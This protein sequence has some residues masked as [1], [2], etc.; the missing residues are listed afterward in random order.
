MILAHG[1][2]IQLPNNCSWKVSYWSRIICAVSIETVAPLQTT[3]KCEQIKW[4]WMN[5]ITGLC[6]FKLYIVKKI[7]V[8]GNWWRNFR[9]K[10][11]R[12]SR[13]F[14]KNRLK[15]VKTAHRTWQVEAL[16]R[17]NSDKQLLSKF[18]PIRRCLRLPRSLTS[19]MVVFVPRV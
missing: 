8:L 2:V 15:K 16:T 19:R 11:G 9:L 14:F 4:R 6:W 1:I 10:P 5:S 17:P 3:A 18:P 12:K 7:M 13:W